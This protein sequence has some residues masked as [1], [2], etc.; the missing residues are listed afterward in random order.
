MPEALSIFDYGSFVGFMKAA[1]EALAMTML[2]VC[3]D[4]KCSKDA[5]DLAIKNSSKVM[6]DENG[7]PER[8]GVLH[9]TDSLASSDCLE[10]ALGVAI[11]KSGFACGYSTALRSV[12]IRE[13][14]EQSYKQM[15]PGD[16]LQATTRADACFGLLTAPSR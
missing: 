5:N 9:I 14:M 11:F 1:N 7:K 13:R 8:D 16:E 4:G 12:L 6:V 2:C 3:R 10:L 15:V